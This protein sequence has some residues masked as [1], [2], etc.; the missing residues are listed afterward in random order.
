M[1]QAALQLVRRGWPVFPCRERDSTVVNSAK[2]EIH[3]KAKAPYG[4]QGLKDAT[5][6]ERRIEAWWRQYPDALIGVPM[7]VNGCF[8]LDFDPRVEDVVDL[9]TGEVTG[10]REYT[11]E[12]LKAELEAQ[13]GV[14]LPPSLT[15]ITQ[16]GGVH[17]WFPHP[18]PQND[19]APQGQGR[20]GRDK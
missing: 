12:E 20:A 1:G 6:D 3:Y 8:A 19:R 16:S 17:V 11:L 5:R 18:A 10:T 14:P 13:I 2:R 9:E 4:G 7:G 15:S